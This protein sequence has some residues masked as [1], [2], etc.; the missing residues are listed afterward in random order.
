MLSHGTHVRCLF[1]MYPNKGFGVESARLAIPVLSMALLATAYGLR[2]LRLHH[3][4]VQVDA[5]P[6]HLGEHSLGV[7]P[8]VERPRGFAGRQAI[9]IQTG[10][11]RAPEPDSSAGA[12]MISELFNSTAGAVQS[13]ARDKNAGWGF[14]GVRPARAALLRDGVVV[15]SKRTICTKGGGGLG[16]VPTACVR[17]RRRR[18]C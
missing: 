7:L 5:D 12:V 16:L 1:R 18:R 13:S 8:C 2:G 17:R 14:P 11:V 4:L 6:L 3:G 15:I 10:Y 9:G